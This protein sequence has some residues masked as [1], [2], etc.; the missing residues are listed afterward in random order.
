MHL[1]LEGDLPPLLHFQQVKRVLIGPLTPSRVSGVG[2]SFTKDHPEGHLFK[3][4]SGPV[5]GNGGHLHLYV[6]LLCKYDKGL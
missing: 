2:I 5:P 3:E 6:T 4:N 1:V